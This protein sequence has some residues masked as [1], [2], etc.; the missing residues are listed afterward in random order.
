MAILNIEVLKKLLEN[1]PE[2]YTVEYDN[3]TTI[4]PLSDK[5]EIDISGKRLIL[6]K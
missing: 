6:K 4:A 2:D 1:L 3:D 5:I